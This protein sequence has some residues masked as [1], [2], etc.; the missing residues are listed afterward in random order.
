[1]VQL[2]NSLSAIKLNSIKKNINKYDES[3]RDK[4]AKAFITAIGLIVNSNDMYN[5]LVDKNLDSGGGVTLSDSGKDKFKNKVKEQIETLTK[6]YENSTNKTEFILKSCDILSREM[7]IASK[8]IKD[9]TVKCKNT[10]NEVQKMDKELSENLNI[11]TIK[12]HINQTNNYVKQ[13]SRVTMS[14]A[15]SI[16]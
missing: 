9:I 14:Y 13:L 7:G 1:M 11:K 16:S 3:K 8:S 12:I 6:S 10:M 4:I 15:K 2:A 5:D